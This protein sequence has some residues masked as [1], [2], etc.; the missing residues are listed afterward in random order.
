MKQDEWAEVGEN[1]SNLQSAALW[2]SPINS[3]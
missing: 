1:Y 3:F 2:S